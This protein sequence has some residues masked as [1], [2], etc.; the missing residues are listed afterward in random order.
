[1]KTKVIALAILVALVVAPLGVARAD[2]DD[3]WE[4]AL[5]ALGA[6]MFLNTLMYGI[7]SPIVPPGAA[8][9]TPR[10][11][12]YYRS[13]YNNYCPPPVVEHY[14]YY[15]DCVPRVNIW[16]ENDPPC[17][18]RPYWRRPRVYNYH[19]HYNY[20]YYYDGHHHRHHHGHHY[21]HGKYCDPYYHSGNCYN[22]SYHYNSY[23]RPRRYIR[24]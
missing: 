11:N 9:Y 15:Y 17:Y 3:R 13:Y 6:T 2:C 20:H 5:I 10:T 22:S 14:S 19:Y 21:D 4:G 12:V 23:Y 8:C 16:I 1:M 18:Y 24:Y 7:A